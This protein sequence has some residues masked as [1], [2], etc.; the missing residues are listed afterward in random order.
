[1]AANPQ[2]ASLSPLQLV[3]TVF[4]LL[5][6]PALLFILAGDWRWPEAW[7][8]TV[9]WLAACFG[10]VIFLYFKDPALLKE[11]YSPNREGQERWD[12]IFIAVFMILF[13]VWFVIMPLDARRF[14]WSPEFPFWVE[15]IGAVMVV[16][17]MGLIIETFRENTFA[18][19]V[20][21]VQEERQQKVISTG[22]YGVIR[23]P[24]YLG[25]LFLFIGPPLLLGSLWGLALG[26]VTIVFIALRSIREEKLLARDLV[27]YS[28]YMKRVRWRLI[29]Y[30]F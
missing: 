27:G 10:C 13:H 28:D 17:S 5:L 26:L 23:H 2:T 9:I 4:F 18:A 19:P 12:K 3:I 7:V 6:Y 16:I 15:V 20:V 30:V 1:M 21:K 24:M 22:L 14:N 11:R 25:A 8:F 29:P